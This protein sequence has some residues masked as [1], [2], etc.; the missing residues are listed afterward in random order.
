IDLLGQ[1][2]HQQVVVDPVERKHHT[3]PISKTFRTPLPS[4]ENAIRLKAKGCKRYGRLI[5]KVSYTCSL[6]SPMKVGR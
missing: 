3:L 2:P 6:S 1:F 4:R 5:D